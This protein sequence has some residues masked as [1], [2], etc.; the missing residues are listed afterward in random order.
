V[1]DFKNWEAW[2]AWVEK[3]PSTVITLSEQTKGVGGAYSWVD[4]DGAGTMKTTETVPNTSIQQDMQFADFPA[5]DISWNFNP[6]EDGSTDVTWT[7]SGKDLPLGFKAYSAFSGGMEKQIGPDFERGLEKLDSTVQASMKVYSITVNGIIQHSGGFYLYN[8]TSSKIDEL[9][10]KIQDML[11]KVRNYVMKNNI[12]MAGAPYINYHKWDEENNAVMFSSSVPTVEKV[13][14][15][16]DSGILTGQLKP[17]K[18]VKTTL[19]GDYENLKEA[20]ATA[21][22]YI[23]ENNLEQVET[24]PTLETYLIDPMSTQNPADYITEIYI[25]VK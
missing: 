2:S 18:A 21:M 10:S 4:K 24:G 8:T 11:P 15:D 12:T 17:F 16:S 23:K 9:A 19:K 3:E 13:I 22:A 5:F 14:T 20:W 1:I 6:N 25:A 7:I